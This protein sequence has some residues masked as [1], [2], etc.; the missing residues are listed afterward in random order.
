MQANV[1]NSALSCNCKSA[2][3]ALK[4]VMLL[5]SGERHREAASMSVPYR[6]AAHGAGVFVVWGANMT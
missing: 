6:C 3:L 5:R 4:P 2:Q 1:T